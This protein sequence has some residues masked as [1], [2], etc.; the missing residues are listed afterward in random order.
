MELFLLAQA[1]LIR[2]NA[3]R[4]HPFRYF[5]LTTL[6][7]FPE[8]RTVVQ[9]KAE[10]DFRITFFT[11]ARSPKVQHILK[12][13]RVSALFYHPK[14]KLQLRLNAEATVQTSGEPYRSFRQ[15][16]EQSGSLKDYTSRRAPGT[17]IQEGIEAQ[18][19]EEVNFAVVQLNP[20]RLDILQLGRE[21]HL[22][23]RYRLQNGVWEEQKVVP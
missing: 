2:S 7:H 23:A 1:E 10:T 21:H 8:V 15:E 13:P 17:P 12:N 18:A 6:D 16:V 9:R 19:G 4:R 5:W 14:K 3:D 20:V 11:D 22:R